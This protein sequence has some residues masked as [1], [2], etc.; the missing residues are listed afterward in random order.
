M[1]LMP[2]DF[3]VYD[4]IDISRNKSLW[5]IYDEEAEKSIQVVHIYEYYPRPKTSHLLRGYAHL[6]V[7]AEPFRFD[8]TT[9]CLPISKFNFNPPPISKVEFLQWCHHSKVIELIFVL[10]FHYVL[11]FTTSLS[12]FIF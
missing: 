4:E 5:N 6:L 9:Q 1:G 8:K 2:Q 7:L 3:L 11:E 12:N 10:L